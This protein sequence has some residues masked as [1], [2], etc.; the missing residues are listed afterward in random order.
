MAF[1][2]VLSKIPNKITAGE[3]V[4]WAVSLSDYPASS[5]WTLTYTLVKSDA[6]IQI[7][8]GSDGDDHIVEVA[9]STSAGYA[10][11]AYAY[12]GHVSNGT[13]RYLVDSGIIEISTDFSGQ[14]TGYDGR[15]HVKKVLDAIEAVLES[16]ASKTQLSQTVGSTQVQHMTLD[17][18]IRARDE[19]RARYLK[20][21]ASCGSMKKR[22][23]K[24]RFYN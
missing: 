19:Y 24:P 9:Y 2:T 5:D 22:V 21:L 10:P 18:L 11:G 23:I 16:R 1:T 6:H 4:S 13:E 15:S 12:Q 14:E 7:V 17:Q 20:E 8:A 3:S